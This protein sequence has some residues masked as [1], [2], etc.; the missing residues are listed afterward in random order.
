MG[1]AENIFFFVLD[2]HSVHLW[3]HHLHGFYRS[4]QRNPKST[5]ITRGGSE[6]GGL[7]AGRV[8]AAHLHL[9]CVSPSGF[10]EAIKHADHREGWERLRCGK[11]RDFSLPRQGGLEGG[12][13]KAEEQGDKLGER[14]SRSFL[15]PLSCGIPLTLPGARA[16]RSRKCFNAFTST[17]RG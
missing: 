5:K 10:K 12:K 8:A 2:M 17:S 6:E 15:H 13:K 3:S 16:T 4:Q 9:I 11:Q 14:S 1:R 7:G